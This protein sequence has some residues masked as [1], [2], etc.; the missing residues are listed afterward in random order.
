MS[1]A[2]MKAGDGAA[3]IRFVERHCRVVKDSIGGKRGDLIRL[4]DWQQLEFYRMLARDPE[5]GRR[6]HRVAL[7]G[8]PRKNGKSG[9]ASGLALWMAD[10]GPGGGEVYCCAGDKEQAK[11]VFATCRSMV[12]L[13]PDLAARVKVYRDELVWPDT[14]TR[15]RAL[16][17][18]AYTKEGL[19]PTGTVFDEVHVQPN[20]ELWDVMALAMGAREEPLMLGI[21]TAGNPADKLGNDTLCYRLYQHGRKVAKGELVD[22][23]FYFSWWEPTPKE[24]KR[25]RQG[26]DGQWH[27]ETIEVV[28][29][30]DPAVWNEANPGLG[31]L[32]SVEDFESAIARTHEAE[33]R[34]K[35]CNLWQVGKQAAVPD[36]R[37]AARFVARPAAR[38]LAGTSSP[39]SPERV[40]FGS[41]LEVPAAWLDD[42]VGFLDGSWSGDSTGVVCSTPDG[43]LFV[44]THHEKT[45]LDGP[46]WRVPV[47]S[48]K[49]DIQLAFEHGLRG[50]LLDPFGWKQTAADLADEGLPVV[51]WPTNSLARIVPAWKDFYAAILDG[52]LSHDGNPALARHVS[53]VVLKIDRFGARPV[54]ATSSSTRH[55]DLAICAIG[56]WSNRA[57]EFGDDK[58]KR[59][60]LWSAV[61]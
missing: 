38:K 19:N 50:L 49:A 21:T 54:K 47:N 58:P 11:I 33:F 61:G 48:V 18:E 59:A 41:G 30:R 52:E 9:K 44:I 40:L 12:E 1:A 27:T 55:I 17:A 20:D 22:R 39:A 8:L 31:D 7:L 37:W 4:R 13:D 53:N 14:E 60:Q 6:R 35:R 25:R 3:A 26:P 43:H 10:E 23:S 32:V 51:E 42:A 56:A 28:D 15:L 29:H 34:T 57:L 24:V 5:T 16:S 2:E 36:G 46:D 45:E